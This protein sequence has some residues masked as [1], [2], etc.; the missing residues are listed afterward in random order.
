MNNQPPSFLKL[1]E[2]IDNTYGEH[3]GEGVNPAPILLSLLQKER[4]KTF[5]LEQKIDYYQKRYLHAR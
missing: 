2:E 4:E 1:L 5:K 3:I